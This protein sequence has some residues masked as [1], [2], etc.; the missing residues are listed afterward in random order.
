MRSGRGKSFRF[1]GLG[2][3][4]WLALVLPSNAAEVLPPSPA[5][6]FSDYARVASSAT[7]DHLNKQLEDFE[8]ATSCQFVVAVFPKME[9][10]SSLEDY[11]HRVFQ[12]WKI[13]LNSKNNG[14]ALFVFVQ[15][16]KLRVEVGYGLEGAL[17]DA[18]CKRIIAE[19]ITPRF[20]AGSLDNGLTSGVSAI[21]QATR[22]EYKGTGRTAV[23]RWKTFRHQFPD[24]LKIVAFAG[25]VPAW[26]GLLVVV[27]YVVFF[28]KR[29]WAKRLRYRHADALNV[30]GKIWLALVLLGIL[31]FVLAMISMGLLAVV[32][33]PFVALPF[34]VMVL[35]AIVVSL[36]QQAIGATAVVF[37]RRG[38]LSWR[39]WN[40]WQTAWE[41]AGSS[42]GGG[43][44]GS[45][46]GGGSSGGFSGGGGS[47]GGGGA[48]GSW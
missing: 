7:A 8:R 48:S 21:I 43:G 33:D 16:R 2:W 27:P 26:L 40:D 47:S 37:H 36:I 6:H 31:G 11:C 18:L 34:V 9:S 13:G 22:G 30:V 46:A 41:T 14:V 12:A 3:L 35:I 32:Q 39:R 10:N 19:Q 44:G 4:L 5:T 15:D 25:W 23:G 20:K 1:S 28:Q 42:A 38:K 17:P 29:A 24:I 45:S